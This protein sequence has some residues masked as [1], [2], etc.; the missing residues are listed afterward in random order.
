MSGP[1]DDLRILGALTVGLGGRELSVSSPKQRVLVASLLLRAGQVVT[2]D[3]L[4]HRIWDDAPPRDTRAALHVHTTRL[5]AVLRGAGTGGTGLPRIETHPGGYRLLIAPDSLDLLRHRRAAGEARRA[6]REGDRRRELDQLE[7][8][9]AEWRGEP[10]GTVPSVSLHTEVVPQLVEEYLTLAE[11][12]FALALA[13]GQAADLIPQLRA[14]VAA[15]PLRERLRQHLMT[16]LQRTGRAALA[17]EEYRDYYRMLDEELGLPPGPELRQLHSRVLAETGEPAAHP[18]GPPADGDPAG[19]APGAR[20]EPEEPEVPTGAGPVNDPAGADPADPCAERA[21]PALRSAWSPNPGAPWL[22]QRQLPPEATH[23]AGRERDQAE[24]TALLTPAR[25][26]SVPLVGI[27]GPPGIG[28]TSLALRTAHRLSHAYPDGQWYV[29]LSDTLGRPRCVSELIA[30]LLHTSGMDVSGLPGERAHLAGVLRSRLAGRRVLIVLDDVHDSAQ[31]AD[32]LPGT[33][34]S[35]VLSVHRAYPPDLVAVHGARLVTLPVL[36]QREAEEVFTAVLGRDRDTVA[37]EAVAELVR[38]CGR[39]PLALRIAGGHLAGRPW[40]TVEDYVTELR[41]GDILCLLDLGDSPSTAVSAAFSVAY[42]SLPAVSRRF[43]RLLGSVGDMSFTAH[44]AGRLADCPPALAERLLDR[45]AAAQ[46]VEAETE[47]PMTYRFHNLIG[48]YAAERGAAEDSETERR[49]ALDR[50]FQWYLRRTDEA[51]RSCYPGFVRLHPAPAEGASGTVEPRSAQLWLRAEHANLVVLVQRAAD[52]RLHEPCVRLV[53]ML[54]GYFMLGRMQTDWL[55]VARAGLRSAE[56]LGDRRA[57]AVMRLGAGLALQGLNELEPAARHLQD[58]R[59]EFVA[60]GARDF[61][62]VTLNALAMN[63]LQ[64]PAKRMESAISLLERALRLSHGLGLRHVQGRGHLY[65]G[66]ARHTQGELPA[67]EFHFRAA[68]AVFRE[69]GVHR[70]RPEVLARLGMVLGERGQGTEAARQL[71]LALTLARELGSPY[72]TALASCGLASLHLGE[73]R[74]ETAHRYAQTAVAIARDQ[75]YAALEANVRNV[76]GGVE[77]AR[78]RFGEAREQFAATL[79]IALRIG[80]PQ[81]R[82]GALIGLG[83]LDLADGRTAE[84]LAHARAAA[85]VAAESELGL[86]GEEA[87]G[88]VRLASGLRDGRATP[89]T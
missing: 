55:T 51:V 10:F 52:A 69:Y 53:D 46:L 71:S 28:K 20:P 39:L 66:M 21:R 32:L 13:L 86:L 70:S 18:A 26:E 31:V 19:P 29:R 34:G 67:A 79:E 64:R 72:S 85:A 16:A 37:P 42:R 57:I 63:Q 45:L 14:L 5:R 47:A 35:A 58:A 56:A 78:G 77:R 84:A 8:A 59:T 65:L 4:I 89:A 15:H 82:A 75:G 60:L 48:R 25:P 74:A 11:R 87:G 38:L 22:V 23:F 80:H 73:G 24:L 12:R 27:V 88:L 62:V 6:R 43:F 1:A 33:P 50:L 3:E 54:R 9:L 36:P 49:D 30:E 44:T 7:A 68:A 17:L 61:E 83:R 40:V 2:F 76:L 81:S 41:E